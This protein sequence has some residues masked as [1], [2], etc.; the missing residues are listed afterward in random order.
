MFQMGLPNHSPGAR[1]PQHNIEPWN[2]TNQPWCSQTATNYL[3]HSTL[4]QHNTVDR[5]TE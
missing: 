3:H 4:L 2:S 1:A 5:R